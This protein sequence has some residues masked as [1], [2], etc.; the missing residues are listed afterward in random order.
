MIFLINIVRYY[1]QICSIF[2]YFAK[3]EAF[4][5]NGMVTDAIQAIED[6][7]VTFAPPN[8]KIGM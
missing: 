4:L 6:S 5:A 3:A 1:F 2:F 8:K 7:L